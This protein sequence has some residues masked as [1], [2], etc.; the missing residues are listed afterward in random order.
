MAAE[1]ITDNQSRIPPMKFLGNILIFFFLDWESA[2]AKEDFD[3]QKPN[4]AST[5][6]VATDP[7]LF[8]QEVK[9][10]QPPNILTHRPIT[11]EPPRIENQQLRAEQSI[12]S[13]DGSTTSEMSGHDS[14]SIYETIR[15][16]TPRKQRK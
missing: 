11:P 16:F 14:E 7:L 4:Q 9:S 1:R 10:A 6:I 12:L 8:R 15:V 13:D 5:E 3:N 2:N